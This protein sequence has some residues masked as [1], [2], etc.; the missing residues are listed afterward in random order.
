MIQGKSRE[1]V[2]ALKSQHMGSCSGDSPELAVISTPN[3]SEK[4]DDRSTRVVLKSEQISFGW[5]EAV[6]GKS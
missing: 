3:A 4:S 2:N 5:A 1:I 6:T